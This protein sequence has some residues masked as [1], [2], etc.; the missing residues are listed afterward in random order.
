MFLKLDL[1]GQKVYICSH[2]AISSMGRVNH[3][4][5]R[6]FTWGREDSISSAKIQTK[7]IV[8]NCIFASFQ[9]D[10]A[11]SWPGIK[12]TNSFVTYPAKTLYFG[13]P[14]VQ[15]QFCCINYEKFSLLNFILK[16][17]LNV[18]RAINVFYRAN[19]SLFQMGYSLKHCCKYLQRY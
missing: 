1:F 10:L 8:K 12:A 11:C 4:G 14:G 17:V 9:G 16:T 15:Y 5:T 19:L 6:R 2:F 3:V 7:K 18:W 13:L